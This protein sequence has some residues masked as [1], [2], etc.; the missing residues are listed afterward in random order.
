MKQTLDLFFPS[1]K[2][3]TDIAKAKSENDYKR[4]FLIIC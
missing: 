2:E 4:Q 1:L 3:F